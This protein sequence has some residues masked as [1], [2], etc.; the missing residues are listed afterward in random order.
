MILGLFLFKE[1]LGQIQASMN[2]LEISQIDLNSKYSKTEKCTAILRGLATIAHSYQEIQQKLL[3]KPD[4]W[5][6]VSVEGSIEQ[7]TLLA[8]LTSAEI[9]RAVQVNKISLEWVFESLLIAYSSR[10]VV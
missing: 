3:C 2:S 8:D 7:D 5:I 6:H 4:H 9:G 10:Q 1:T